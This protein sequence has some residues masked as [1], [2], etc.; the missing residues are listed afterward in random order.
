MT[1]KIYTIDNPKTIKAMVKFRMKHGHKPLP[2]RIWEQIIFEIGS[3][4][5]GVAQVVLGN[6]DDGKIFIV[7]GVGTAE[8]VVKLPLDTIASFPKGLQEIIFEAR[9]SGEYNRI[10]TVR[11]MA[12]NKDTGQ[13]AM[14][15]MGEL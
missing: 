11:G 7:E 4:T 3:A 15:K 6:C 13:I 14:W 8:E 10:S 2:I 1:I 5:L 9:K 12:I